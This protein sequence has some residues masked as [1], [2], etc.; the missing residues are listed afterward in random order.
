MSDFRRLMQKLGKLERL[1]SFWTGTF[2]HLLCLCFWWF[3]GTTLMQSVQLNIFPHLH[4]LKLTP[5]EYINPATNGVFHLSIWTWKQ[6]S[7]AS[8]KPHVSSCGHNTVHI[9]TPLK[10]PFAPL[11]PHQTFNWYHLTVCS[12][13]IP[14][15]FT[16]WSAKSWIRP[17]LFILNTIK[18]RSFP[19]LSLVNH[20]LHFLASSLL[21][22]LSGW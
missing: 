18:F 9:G 5:Y 11:F 15:R 6:F 8:S 1:Q 13:R 3:V 14:T 2:V 21:F 4:L 20:H 16:L 22:L 12:S 17:W 10:E 19:S 7:L